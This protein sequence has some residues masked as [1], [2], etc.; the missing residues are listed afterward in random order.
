MSLL[1]VSGANT[2]VYG[3]D[4]AGENIFNKREDVADWMKTAGTNM[5]LRGHLC[6]SGLEK[7]LFYAPTDIE[8]HQ[9]FVRPILP[10]T[11]QPSLLVLH[12]SSIHPPGTHSTGSKGGISPDPPCL[13]VHPI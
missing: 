10:A 4:N 2:L 1:P 5:G 8:V 3:S 13:V 12:A 7:A 6:G 11:Q 9:G